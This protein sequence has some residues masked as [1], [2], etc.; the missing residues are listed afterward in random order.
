MTSAEISADGASLSRMVF[1]RRA[2]SGWQRRD[3]IAVGAV[4]LI[5]GLL[6][7]VRLGVPRSLVFDE[8][9]YARD[10]CWYVFSSK[11]ICGM[12]GLVL[13]DR[14]V[15][16][17]LRT[18]SEL[19][20]EHPPLGKWLIAVGIWLF[21]YRTGAWRIASV[22]AGTATIALLYLL[23]RKL[24]RSTTGAT[25]ASAL[26]AI[27]FLHFVQSR[28]A[29]LE[30]FVAFFGVAAFLCCTYDRDQI[31]AHPDGRA[32]LWQLRWRIAAGVL[33]GGAAA[34]KLSGW[35]IV[36]GLI[37]L[38]FACAVHARRS[39]GLPRALLR[40]FHEE[41]TSI[42]FALVALPVIVYSLTYTG[43][44]EGAI[45]AWPWQADSL[46]HAF[47]SRQ[48][49]MLG[50]HGDAL[51]RTTA[52]STLVFPAL[53]SPMMYFRDTSGADTQVI[54]LFGN[55][56]VWGPAV[57]ALLLIALRC[58]RVRKFGYAEATILAAFLV[59]YG[60]WLLITWSRPQVFL[61]YF[62]P[63]VPFAALALG[64]V[65][66]SSDVPYIVR[67]MFGVLLVLAGLSFAFFYPVLAAV[68][69]STAAY[70]T[71]TYAAELITH[72]FR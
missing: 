13:D 9:W 12:A 57:A 15:D 33:G 67:R 45:L 46:V 42:V 22:V 54:L 71:R 60:G 4:T 41:A 69:L 19:T 31:L 52:S 43:R 18:F 5:G 59:N 7:V 16:V 32:T 53:A 38:V 8:F 27:D 37:A 61:H 34:C 51:T 28:L 72:A 44:L 68:P 29:M 66:A 63:V 50:F 24:L 23:A 40:A 49:N 70:E 20:P 35:L 30:I 10:A 26:L 55:P 47:T 65:A 25:V 3:W 21:G 17:W 62:T 39:D 56:F 58:V 11:Q 36:L 2:Q 14:E 48:M 1:S 6:R 64:Y